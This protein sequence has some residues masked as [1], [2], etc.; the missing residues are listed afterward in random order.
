MSEREK[1]FCD[2]PAVLDE[3]KKKV[4]CA[5]EMAKGYKDKKRC[6]ECP[7]VRYLHVRENPTPTMTVAPLR[8]RDKRHI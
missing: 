7:K 4:N 2:Y 3:V 1:M 8:Q 6:S 5:P